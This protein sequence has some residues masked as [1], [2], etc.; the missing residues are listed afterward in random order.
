MLETLYGEQALYRGGMTIKTTLDKTLQE[1]LRRQ[2]KSSDGTS[3]TGPDHVTVIEQENKIRAI[4]CTEGKE[5]ELRA[6]LDSPLP[7]IGNYTVITL[8]PESVT[9]EQIVLPSS[10][11]GTPLSP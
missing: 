10:Q 9:R 2:E 8:A 7:V 5:A 4:V 6:K 11:T 1:E 3:A